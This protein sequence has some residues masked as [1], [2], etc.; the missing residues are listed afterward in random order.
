MAVTRITFRL[1]GAEADDTTGGMPIDGIDLKIY[2]RRQARDKQIEKNYHISD[3][4]FRL[5]N[6]ISSEAAINLILCEVAHSISPSI[7]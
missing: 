5:R 1:A 4:A 3:S 7:V 2:F 6:D